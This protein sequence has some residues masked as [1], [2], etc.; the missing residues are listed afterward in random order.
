MTLELQKKLAE[1]G[2]T[3]HLN[4]I[5]GPSGSCLCN[6]L[7]EG[8]GWHGAWDI[9]GCTTPHHAED[10]G[11]K[12]YTFTIFYNHLHKPL[13]FITKLS[14]W[15]FPHF[16][17]TQTRSFA[18]VLGEGCTYCTFDGL[19]EVGDNTT[20]YPYPPC[21]TRC[22]VSFPDV[23]FKR[24]EHID[25]GHVYWLFTDFFSSSKI[26]KQFFSHQNRTHV[27][28]VYSIGWWVLFWCRPFEHCCGISMALQGFE[29]LATD[30]QRSLLRKRVYNIL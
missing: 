3:C 20:S 23:F 17:T 10:I 13:P 14:W 18:S 22:S 11:H 7:W 21:S 15:H 26:S 5:C 2:T 8:H 25:V 30:I 28:I 9:M 19:P 4:G 1:F 6:D 29:A 16:S 27:Y 12:M 24:F